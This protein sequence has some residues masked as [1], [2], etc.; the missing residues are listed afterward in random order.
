MLPEANKKERKE[1]GG[2][3]SHLVHPLQIFYYGYQ[4]Y[5][6]APKPELKTTGDAYSVRLW[7]YVLLIPVVWW[8][9]INFLPLLLFLPYLFMDMEVDTAFNFG[10]ILSLILSFF[11][12]LMIYSFCTNNR[13]LPFRLNILSDYESRI[14]PHLFGWAKERNALPITVIGMVIDFAIGWSVLYLMAIFM[15]LSFNDDVLVGTVSTDLLFFV[16]TF[17]LIAIFVP[18]VEELLFRGLVLDL[19]CEKY[20]IGVSILISSVI[21]GFLHIHPVSIFNAFC[22]GMI[23]GYV[24]IRTDSLWPSIILHAFWNGHLVVLEFFYW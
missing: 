21:F 1:N 8:F 6:R 14:V 7:F 2:G 9:G 3:P 4:W 24:R 12:I 22:G 11:I 10:S 18:I 13:E 20:S 15:G 5:Y 17:L 19:L 16:S 23:Y